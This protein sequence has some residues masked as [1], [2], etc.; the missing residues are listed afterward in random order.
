M[1]FPIGIMRL[2]LWFLVSTYV[3]NGVPLKIVPAL[4]K[5]C[6]LGN[7]EEFFLVATVFDVRMLVDMNFW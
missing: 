5:S 2:L 4:A 6:I 3:F 1:I 7:I